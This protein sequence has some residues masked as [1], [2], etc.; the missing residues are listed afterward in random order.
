[1]SR[2][3]FNNGPNFE[4]GNSTEILNPDPTASHLQVMLLLLPPLLPVSF[5]LCLCLSVSVFVSL[6]LSLCASL[7]P[8]LP[9]SLSH[10]CGCC[11]QIIQGQGVRIRD[12]WFS[13]L[14]NGLELVDS[15]LM[16]VERS[17]F[18]GLWDRH[19]PALQDSQVPP[20]TFRLVARLLIDS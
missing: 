20:R 12:C 10:H 2:Y 4:A 3:A 7:S 5:C 8:A 16:W 11:L 6:S 17:I 1:M 19:T 18:N 9:G 13:N 14:G 15:S